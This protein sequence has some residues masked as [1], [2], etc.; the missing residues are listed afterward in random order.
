MWLFKRKK[1]TPK[2]GAFSPVCSFCN[3]T[4]TRIFN[5]TD[6]EHPDFIKTW[7]GHRYVTC[8]CLDCGRDFYVNEPETG[9]TTEAAEG[10]EI[11]EDEETLRA[12]EEELKR[13]I[14]DSND[15][16]CG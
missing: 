8:R 12:A 1:P 9:I 13:E 6:S 11:V 14:E 16:R 15:R 7:R 10:N 3:S 4:H 2:N 5:R